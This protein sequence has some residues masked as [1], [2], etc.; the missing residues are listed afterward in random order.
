MEDC[1][2]RRPRD[3]CPGR[4]RTGVRVA[5]IESGTVCTESLRRCTEDLATA[6]EAEPKCAESRSQ[7]PQSPTNCI[8]AGSKCTEPEPEQTIS[9]QS[10]SSLPRRTLS[11]AQIRC[12][13]R[14]SAQYL[15]RVASNP[16]KSASNLRQSKPSLEP[17]RCTPAQSAQYLAKVHRIRVRV[18]R[19]F[20]KANLLRSQF[21]ALR[22]RLH[23][24]VAKVHR[25]CWRVHRIYSPAAR[26]E[27]AGSLGFVRKP[28]RPAKSRKGRLAE[29]AQRALGVGTASN[30]LRT[31]AA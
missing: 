12:T 27:T 10:R 28:R 24:T 17:I 25:P 22:A 20:H 30:F 2:R 21:D 15:A 18:H 1:P 13:L 16:A 7:G 14:R 11:P 9:S 5:W 8:K 19:I 3:R 29:W 26:A 4:G 23:S 31:T 6:G